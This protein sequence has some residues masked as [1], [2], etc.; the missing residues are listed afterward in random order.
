MIELAIGKTESGHSDRKKTKSRSN[1][2]LEFKTTLSESGSYEQCRDVQLSVGFM[3]GEELWRCV[4]SIFV[5]VVC[6]VNFGK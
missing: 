4:K 5:I 6:E 3:N 1:R 2:T